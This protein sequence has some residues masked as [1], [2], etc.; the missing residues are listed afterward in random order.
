MTLF[1]LPFSELVFK[2]NTKKVIKKRSALSRGMPLTKRSKGPEGAKESAPASPTNP[3]PTGILATTSSLNPEDVRS[4][5][6]L[7]N[8]PIEDLHLLSPEKTVLEIRGAPE[9]SSHS[10]ITEGPKGDERP[11]VEEE[12]VVIIGTKEAPNQTSFPM[13]LGEHTPESNSQDGFGF[14]VKGYTFLPL[15]QV[16]LE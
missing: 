10:L 2:V 14:F 7:M 15:S 5:V 6:D 12:K 8:A 9:T 11:R 1:H 13:G 4:W 16:V 3:K